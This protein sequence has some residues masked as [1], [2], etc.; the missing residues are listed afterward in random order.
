MNLLSGRYETIDENDMWYCQFSKNKPIE[1]KINIKS[2]KGV[3]GI[4]IWNYNKSLLESGKGAKSV[5]VRI[6]EVDFHK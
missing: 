2:V 3:G 1:L 4:C 6:F 5:E